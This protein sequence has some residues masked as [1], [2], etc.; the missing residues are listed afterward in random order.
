[1]AQQINTFISSYF[2]IQDNVFTNYVIFRED[3][4]QITEISKVFREL[5][6]KTRRPWPFFQKYWKTQLTETVNYLKERL[7]LIDLDCITSE[8]L[9]VLREK[10][11]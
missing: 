7:L 8:K 5:G 10:F 6:I 3:S 9:E 2:P 4:D 1:M 11:S